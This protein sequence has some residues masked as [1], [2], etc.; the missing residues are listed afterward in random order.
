MNNRTQMLGEDQLPSLGWCNS[1][2]IPVFASS[3]LGGGDVPQLAAKCEQHALVKERP[4]GAA[5][6]LE[7]SRSCP[8][9]CCALVGMKR[10]T[11]VASNLALMKFPTLDEET[12]AALCADLFSE[13]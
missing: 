10:P 4:E 9:V 13:Q 5:R 8:G 11:N 7:F 12:H 3:S 1:S 2:G 6:W